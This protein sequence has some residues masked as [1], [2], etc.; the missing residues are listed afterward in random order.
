MVKIS[1]NY[2][3]MNTVAANSL[4]N[5]LRSDTKWK[6]DITALGAFIS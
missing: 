6:G 5:G 3:R 2:P 4:Y 1:V